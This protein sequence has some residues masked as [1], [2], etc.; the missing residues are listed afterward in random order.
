MSGLTVDIDQGLVE[1]IIRAHIEAAIVCQ[2]EQDENLIP[3]LVQAA[4]AHKVD[5]D[6]K[7]SKYSSDNKYLYIDMLCKKAIQSAAR[8]A[9]KEYIG[10]NT[11][12]LQVEVKKQ[13]E[14]HTGTLAKIFVDSLVGG[15]KSEWRFS[16]NVDLPKEK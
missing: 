8:Q 15:L 12:R 5:H 11:E 4:L 2:L 10:E 6:G 3:K 16:V 13:L 1:P 7:R 14:S 9:M